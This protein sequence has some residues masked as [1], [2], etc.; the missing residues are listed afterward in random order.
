MYYG[1]TILELAVSQALLL[2]AFLFA[3]FDLI[4]LI[5]T[6]GAGVIAMSIAAVVASVLFAR[7]RSRLATREFGHKLEQLRHLP[8]A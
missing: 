1:R 6:F 3:P 2:A 7:H 5:G 4:S 8:T